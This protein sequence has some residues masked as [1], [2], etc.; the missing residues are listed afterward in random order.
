MKDSRH[1]T[2]P[3]STRRRFK[4]GLGRYFS[5]RHHYGWKAV[6]RRVRYRNMLWERAPVSFIVAG[7]SLTIFIIIV[8]LFN[9][10][11][12][13]FLIFLLLGILLIMSILEIWYMGAD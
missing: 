8:D 3:G 13:P 6:H 4:R 9:V 2:F 1:Y 5:L 7:V 10:E 12:H 11:V